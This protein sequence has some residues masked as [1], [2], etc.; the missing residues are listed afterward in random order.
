VPSAGN[1][2]H[3]AQIVRDHAE[4]RRLLDAARRLQADLYTGSSPAEVLAR[5]ERDLFA[6]SNRGLEHRTLEQRM[7]D[8]V[9]HVDRDGAPILGSWPFSRLNDMTGGVWPGHLTVLGGIT[10]HGKSVMVDQILEG[11]TKRGVKCAAYLNEMTVRE[12]DLRFIARRAD[13]PL[14]RL[15]L[16]KLKEGEHGRFI[17][18][19]QELPYEIVP[20]AG[21]TAQELV[22]DIRRRGWQV[23]ALDLLNGLPGSSR[24]EDIDENI[25][26][27]STGAVETGCHIIGCQHLS[28][29]R[30]VGSYPPEPVL[31][32][33]RG[34]SAIENLASNVM[35]VYRHE[36]EDDQGPTGRPGDDAYVE[37]A[38]VRMGI[39]GRVEVS[40]QG[41]R[42]RF[43]PLAHPEPARAA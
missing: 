4:A 39:V 38:K 15:M 2:R 13:I 32:D 33:L 21:M 14:M 17:R 3:Y 31:S 8:L 28:R 40:F 18:A 11:L 43:L 22:R 26:V 34:S 10:S 5:H 27:L 7:D 19:V 16:G 30:N 29:N 20:A 42:M 37:F 24:V 35:F 6:I 23:V 36:A 25:R 1:V 12:R 41:S 9:D